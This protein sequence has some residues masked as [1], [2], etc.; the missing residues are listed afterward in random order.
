MNILK[1]AHKNLEETVK[2]RIIDTELQALLNELELICSDPE[3]FK[4]AEIGRD[5]DPEHK[6]LKLT[7]IFKQVDD[8]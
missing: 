8:E 7:F 4:V 6:R 3:H 2:S 1:E 5:L